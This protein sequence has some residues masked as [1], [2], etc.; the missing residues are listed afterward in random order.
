[1]RKT[2]KYTKHRKN[3]RTVKKNKKNKK[4]IKGGSKKT[5]PITSIFLTDPIFKAI[6]ILNPDFKPKGFKKDPDNHGFKLHK[7]NESQ[8]LTIPISVKPYNKNP[9]YFSII[10]GRHRFAKLVARG[11]NTIKITITNS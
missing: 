7:L 2:Y 3:N 8:D 9:E 11:N 6:K 4:T 10:N 1:M 5:V